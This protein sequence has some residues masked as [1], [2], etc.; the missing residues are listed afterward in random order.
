MNVDTDHNA[1]VGIDL[2]HKEVHD[3]N[4]FMTS[5]KVADTGTWADDATIDIIFKVADKNAH[6]SFIVAAEGAAQLDI[7]RDATQDATTGAS[8]GTAM[9][10]HKVNDATTGVSVASIN[11]D[12][13]L[14]ADGTNVLTAFIPGGSGPKTNGDILR[15]GT[16]LVWEGDSGLY[17]L[18]LINLG[19]AA[20]EGSVG[21]NWYESS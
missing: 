19:G 4:T 10:A 14:S 16:E 17:L 20:K 18:R 1:L 6:I 3:G 13:D 11:L 2:P 12:M 5:Y 21:L 15:S 9:T 8:T 7:Y